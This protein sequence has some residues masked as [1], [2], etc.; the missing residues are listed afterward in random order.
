VVREDLAH[1]Q[2]GLAL[3]ERRACS[4]INAD[5]KMIREHRLTRCSCGLKGFW[6]AVTDLIFPNLRKLAQRPGSIGNA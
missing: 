6:R 4:I 5:R 3:S 2:A 1:L